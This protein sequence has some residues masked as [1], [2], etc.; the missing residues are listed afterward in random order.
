MNILCTFHISVSWVCYTIW[1]G[2]R[3]DKSFISF[4]LHS[5]G[6]GYYKGV[7]IDINMDGLYFLTNKKKPMDLDITRGLELT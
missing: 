5:H 3:L 7:E 4:K 1:P 2:G 6:F